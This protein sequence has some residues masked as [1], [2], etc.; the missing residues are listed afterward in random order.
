MIFTDSNGNH[1]VIEP[2]D[3]TF[4]VPTTDSVN[5]SIKY[6]KKYGYIGRY[7]STTESFTLNVKV[8]NSD[9]AS[10]IRSLTIKI[11]S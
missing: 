8:T 2:V 7:A 6:N 9:G 5:S 10:C 4:E 3:D 1:T 11:V